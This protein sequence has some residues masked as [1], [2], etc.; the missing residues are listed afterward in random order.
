M[1]QKGCCCSS[2]AQTRSQIMRGRSFP[3]AMMSTKSKPIWRHATW[4][5]T[6]YMVCTVVEPQKKL[7]V[8]KPGK[9]SINAQRRTALY[10]HD[11][12]STKSFTLH[13][14]NESQCESLDR[15]W[16]GEVW[17]PVEKY[18]REVQSS[19]SQDCVLDPAELDLDLD[20]MSQ[21]CAFCD[22]K[23]ETQHMRY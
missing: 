19:I 3:F 12:K 23:R 5:T 4:N 18:A 9:W 8:F 6:D 15:P 20:K 1:K 16:F 14:D 17:L 21:H 2:Q 7:P 22:L 10:G 13:L 11:A